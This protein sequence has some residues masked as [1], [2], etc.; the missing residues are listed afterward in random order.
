MDFNAPSRPPKGESIVPMI[1]V[2]FLLLV[3]FLMTAQIAPPDPFEVT[4]PSAIEAVEPETE[5]TLYVGQNDA[6]QFQ[7]VSGE[8]AYA[9][10]TALSETGAGL[11]L[12]IDATLDG[13]TLAVAMRKLAKAGFATVEVV[14]ETK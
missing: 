8:A 10:L 6:I 12:R 7:D 4:P 14:V 13:D 2:V 1:N 3:F 9:A 11:Q 5:L